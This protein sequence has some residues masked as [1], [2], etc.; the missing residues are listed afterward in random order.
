M[1]KK[2]FMKRYLCEE[3]SSRLLEEALRLSIQFN[4]KGYETEPVADHPSAGVELVVRKKGLEASLHLCE[5]LLDEWGKT[6]LEMEA[7]T[8]MVVQTKWGTGVTNQT[9]FK[10]C[11]D[12]FTDP[13]VRYKPMSSKRPG[14]RLMFTN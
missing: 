13:Y 11:D 10:D 2:V 3:S 14:P 4:L 12:I 5:W 9:Y 6:Q 8:Q 7:R 1:N